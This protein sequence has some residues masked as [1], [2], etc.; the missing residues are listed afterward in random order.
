MW[1]GAYEVA[2]HITFQRFTGNQIAKIYKHRDW[3]AY[4]HY[5]NTEVIVVPT[6]SAPDNDLSVYSASHWLAALE[7]VSY[8]ECMHLLI[9]VMVGGCMYVQSL[10]SLSIALKALV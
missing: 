5:D 9:T 1:P 2:Y 3:P 7:Q 4:Q 10:L 6:L 8:L